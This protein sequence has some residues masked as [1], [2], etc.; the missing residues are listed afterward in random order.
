MPLPFLAAMG[1][2][3]DIA[4]PVM[5]H[6][7]NV[8]NRKFAR[9][10]YNTQRK[11]SLA[12]W[13]TQN[14]YNSPKAQ[15]ERFK[16]AGLNPHLIYGQTNQ[17]APIRTSSAPAASGQAPQ[18]TGEGLRAGY[19]VE[20]SKA[21]MDQL[22]ESTQNIIK[23]RDVMDAEILSKLKAAGFTDVRIAEIKQNMDQKKTLFPH[24][25][26]NLQ[27]SNQKSSQDITIA[28]R[29]DLRE[30]IT[31]KGNLQEQAE[32]IAT[33]KKGREKTQADINEIKQKIELMK[34]DGTLRDYD[35]A[36]RKAGGNPNDPTALKLIDG[37][38]KR[39]GFT[40]DFDVPGE[41]EDMR[42]MFKGKVKP[43]MNQNP[44]KYRATDSQ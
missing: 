35:I 28:W 42:G 8:K 25:L 19:A 20:L 3:E 33:L 44:T 2:A 12:D 16:E 21:Q 17:A 10:M 14:A 43:W 9:E 23:Q 41:I 11:D 31:M 38:L 18:A 36:Y 27:L 22:K 6:L 26:E 5:Q 13:A 39:L 15:M 30:A 37:I 1:V 7:Q 24:Q 4:N 40:G 32:R 34:K 29:R